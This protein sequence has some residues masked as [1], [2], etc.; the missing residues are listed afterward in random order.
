MIRVPAVY[1]ESAEGTILAFLPFREINNLRVLNEPCGFEP[2]PAHQIF[3][4]EISFAA[5][6]NYPYVVLYDN[7]AI[8]TLCR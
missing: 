4:P 7:L 2:R 8:M 3:F 1:L 5:T 6:Y